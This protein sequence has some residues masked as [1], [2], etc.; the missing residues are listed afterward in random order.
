MSEANDRIHELINQVES[1]QAEL[2]AEKARILEL[3]KLN[4]SQLSVFDDALT[5]KDAEIE[6]LQT[7]V[8]DLPCGDT[9]GNVACLATPSPGLTLHAATWRRV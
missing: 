3:W 5:T 8:A 6:R 9:T 7:L 2:G 1:L 4:C